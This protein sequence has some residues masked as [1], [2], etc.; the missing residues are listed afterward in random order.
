MADSTDYRLLIVGAA[1]KGATSTLVKDYVDKVLSPFLRGL[2]NVKFQNLIKN[3]ISRYIKN[4]EHRT[5]T[6]PSIAIPQGVFHL[7]NVYEPL[8]VKSDTEVASFVI[9][10]Y[11]VDLF[12][13]SRCVAFTDDAGM[14]KSTLAKFVVRTALS[15][16]KH[17]PIFV[18]LRRL[19]VGGSILGALCEELANDSPGSVAGIELTSLIS[20]GN[21]LFVFDGYDELDDEVR[22]LVTEEI[23]D[24]SLR[25]RFCYF[26]L[27]SRKE[28]GTSIFPEF[29][30]FEICKLKEA[31]A[32]SLIQRY[33]QG[34]GLAK[35]LINKI[36]EAGVKDFLGNPLLVT[37]LYKAFDY[38]P[39]IPPK[40]GIFFRQVYDALFQDH[41]L[42]KGGGSER[43]KQCGLDVDDFHKF[44]RSLGFVTLKSGRV[45]YSGEEFCKHLEAAVERSSLAIE[46]QKIK[47]DLIRAVP[48]F[49]KDGVEYRWAHKAFQEYFAAQYIAYDLPS[50]REDAVKRMFESSEVSRYKEVLR[51]VAETDI[52]LVRDVCIEPL[53]SESYMDEITD[54][55]FVSKIIFKAADIF[56][57]NNIES[58]GGVSHNPSSLRS[59]VEDAFGI[60]LA[61]R[62][63]RF[64]RDIGS[65]FLVLAALKPDGAKLLL[66]PYL[67]KENF[68]IGARADEER[69]YKHWVKLFGSAATHINPDL[70]SQN[71]AI[72]FS[73]GFKG[74]SV[75][76]Q[77]PAI[78]VEVYKRIKAE[79]S[80]RAGS[81]NDS[82]FD[83]F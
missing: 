4:L 54:D 72:D 83:G 21:F 61:G 9:D 12:F 37:L 48:I 50:K 7:E 29:S 34:R 58:L 16:G 51:F 74:L 5:R 13:H 81:L 78:S 44:V 26:L 6:L 20:N 47:S 27:T 39:T 14:G 22:D 65:N 55:G 64:F 3:N 8:T 80:K 38:R 43:R 71:R 56:F 60:S 24:L 23:N 53:L 76:V 69:L 82:I 30:H 1:V 66:F 73:D 2:K 67:D 62:G 11:P 59:V 25:F 45:S 28:Y 40:R 77:V 35:A 19:R 46:W 31:Q 33:D 70:E 49:V 42:S 36:N 57:I 79:K 52:G 63:F 18:E 75:S 32:H 15:E 41:D 10:A 68:A 17:I